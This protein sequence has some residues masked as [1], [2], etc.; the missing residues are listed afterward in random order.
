MAVNEVLLRWEHAPKVWWTHISQGTY[1]G[2]VAGV[3]V[4]VQYSL[5]TTRWMTTLS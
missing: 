5:A 3:S 2:H 4:G 1:S